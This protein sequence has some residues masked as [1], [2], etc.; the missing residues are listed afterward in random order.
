MDNELKQIAKFLASCELTGYKPDVSTDAMKKAINILNNHDDSQK[1]SVL[2]SI[3]SENV[4]N[5]VCQHHHKDI[6]HYPD[7]VG[8]CKCGLRKGFDFGI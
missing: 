1:S 2:P 3:I 4:V 5:G 6:K 7:D 8:I